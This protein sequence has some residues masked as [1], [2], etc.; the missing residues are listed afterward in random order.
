MHKNV[1]NKF[2]EWG[3]LFTCLTTRAI[4][5]ELA[6]SLNTSSAIMSIQRLAAR[7]GIP[8]VMYSDN[9]TN[10]RKELKEEI[11]TIDNN[12]MNDFML[13]N[14]KFRAKKYCTRC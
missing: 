13:K 2:V 9:G 3:V 8:L 12:G 11:E 7:R 4:N 14:G 10:F 5:I 1:N 6:H